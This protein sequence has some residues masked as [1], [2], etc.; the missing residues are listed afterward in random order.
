M[1]SSPTLWRLAG[2]AGALLCAANAQAQALASS[3]PLDPVTVT[4]SRIEQ[5]LSR[6]LGDVTVVDAETIQRAG[7]S[8]LA[9][10]LQR[11]HGID[12]GTNGGPQTTTSVFIR[13]ANSRH[14]LVLIDG[15]RVGAATSGA[16]SLNGIDP[17]SVERI[18]ILRGAASSIYGADA[19]GGV[20][21]IITKRQ[22]DRPL[23][24]GGSVGAGSHDTYKARI[25]LNGAQGMWTYGLQYG[26]SR[27]RGFNATLPGSFA[28]YGDRDGYEQEDAAARLGL[29]WAAGHR[30]EAS[31]YHSRINGQY[32]NNGIAYDSRAVTRVEAY[33]LSSV[34]R[35]TEAWTSTLRFGRTVDDYRDYPSAAGPNDRARTRQDQFT[36]QNDFALAAGQS[37]SLIAEHLREDVL[38]TSL[39]GSFPTRR[40]TNSAAAIYR[41]DFGPHHIQANLRHDH[42]SQYGGNTSGAVS[43][44][45]D[46]APGWQATASAGTGF[47]AP[48]YSDLYGWG[49]NPDLKAEK[50]RNVEAGLR[51]RKD[52]T[53]A[54]VTAF[55]NR[56]SNLIVWVDDGTGNWTG[57][58]ANVDK[59]ILKGV[60]ISAAQQL[61]ATTLRASADWLDPRDA[62]T[63]EQLARRARG[64]F[65]LAADHRLGPWLLGAE[66]LATTPR[67]DYAG[68]VGRLGGYSLV[69]LTAAYDINRN[70]Q[71]QVRWNNAFNKHY[72]LAGGYATPGS[73]VFVN[74]SYRP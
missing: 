18:E 65:R 48:T 52:G 40:R 8:S 4:A 64:S 47:R 73:T 12:I 3:T 19:I 49:G 16:M 9:E 68:A 6:A 15:M 53:T 26:K 13:G 20:V 61:G 37:L 7:Q 14:T 36:W 31:V 43:Y 60:N 2:A 22:A 32:D 1:S 17:A 5:P 10:L 71:V 44:G 72:E 51:Y 74:L 57:S 23:A 59:A 70:T 42:N 50:S 45:Y 21:N 24:I 28:Y 66:W 27:S 55:R 54:S 63:G 30:V 39:T 56:V 33:S 67:V 38:S 11:E 69:N 46:F 41:G 62:R 29:A 35:I 25:D 34:D 58:N